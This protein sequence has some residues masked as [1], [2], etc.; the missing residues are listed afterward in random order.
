MLACFQAQVREGGD[1]PQRQREGQPCLVGAEG[2]GEGVR[3]SAVRRYPLGEERLCS[4]MCEEETRVRV[5]ALALP[6]P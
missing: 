4:G 1:G 5:R 3:A 6:V 2:G